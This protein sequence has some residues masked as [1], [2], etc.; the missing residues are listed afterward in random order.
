MTKNM[1][2]LCCGKTVRPSYKDLYDDRY[3]A[4]GYFTIY[5]CSN[6]GF[7]RTYPVLK[8]KEIGKFYAKYYPIR[9]Q[10]AS[11]VQKQMNLKSHFDSWRDGT[12]NVAHQYVAKNSD[13][14]DV[15]SANGVS[16][17]EIKKL[18]A[19]AYG[20]EP[21]P[22]SQ[23]LAKQLKI[24][25]FKG[26]LSDNPF[27]GKKFDYITASQVLEHEPDPEQFLKIAKSRLK[28]GGKIILSFPN[29]DSL[30]R[31]IFGKKWIN[32]HVP[33]HVN[34]FSI[35]S[36][37]ILTSK[38]GL[39][40]TKLRTITPNLWTRLQLKNYLLKPT[41]GVPSSIWTTQ[42]VKEDGILTR[43]FFW[44]APYFY[45]PLNRLIDVFGYGDS[46]LVFLEKK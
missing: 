8:R 46:I 2:C 37:G 23:R 44:L 31:R 24:N 19:N 14:L 45:I 5:K 41:M 20:I 33:Y 39:K 42:K 21:D 13:V 15:G 6:C 3:G 11:D 18:G 1:R 17:L 29:A 25:I 34:H 30:Y 10:K 38:I 16:L 40:I 28:E 43:T 27:S 7:G 9:Y 12:N 36:I 4:L 26:F 35:R 22:N 32:W